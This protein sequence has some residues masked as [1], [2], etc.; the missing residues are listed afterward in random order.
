MM[1]ARATVT[2]PSYRAG[3]LAEVPIRPEIPA[4]RVR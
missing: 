4:S 3:L 1:V 2:E